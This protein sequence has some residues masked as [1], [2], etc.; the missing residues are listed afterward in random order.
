MELAQGHRHRL[1]RYALYGGV[2]VLGGVLAYRAYRS[3]AVAQTRASLAR[4]R[5]A[6]QRYSEA[7]SS[8]A[9]LCATLVRDLQHFLQADGSGEVP[10]T[11]RQLA[12][13]LQSRE[14][15]QTTAATVSAL[16]RGLAGA[17]MFG[18]VVAAE[19]ALHCALHMQAS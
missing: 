7:L 11:L 14:V 9:D 1:R 5:L 3:E 19:T 8:G 10:P 18:S 17:C 12:V 6:L 13:L 15:T 16:Y 2:A 4:L